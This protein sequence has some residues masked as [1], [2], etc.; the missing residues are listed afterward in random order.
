MQLGSHPGVAARKPAGGFCFITV[1]QL[2]MAWWAKA[3]GWIRFADLR[4]YLAAH[5]VLAKRCGLKAGVPPRFDLVELCRL[6]GLSLDRVRA[7]LKRLAAAGL[8][9]WS[10]SALSF[11]ESPD[12]L[13]ADLSGFLEF[14]DRIPNHNRRVPVP[15]RILR[16]MAGARPAMIATILGHLFRCLYYRDGRCH[17]YGRCKASWIADTFGVALR[18]VKEARADLIEQGWLLPIESDQW[19]LNRWGAAFTINLAWDRTDSVTAPAVSGP[20]PEPVA[21]PVPTP[22]LAPPPAGFSPELA[23]PREQETLLPVEEE[24]RNQEPASGGPAGFSKSQSGPEEHPESAP[25]PP[26]LQN[27]VPADLKDTGRLFELHEQAQ[28]AGLIGSSESDRL[29]FVAAAEHARAVGSVNP[30]GLFVRI[31]RSKLYPFITQDDEDAANA[32]IKRHLYGKPPSER[33]EGGPSRPME[34]S[35]PRLSED[36]L[37]VQAVKA[38]LARAGY[39]GDPFYALK[40]QRP[41]WTRDRWDRALAEL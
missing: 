31:I 33:V 40:G 21:A 41:E 24:L 22:E 3:Q 2:A 18:R 35:R 34:V 6:T 15:R 39:R 13:N 12:A 4:V 8:M 27:V 20:P 5:E 29:K 26:T 14:L 37:L 23:P 7:S 25:A 28:A 10:Q 11:A 1:A 16:L 36:A 9:S 19:Q 32:R 17:S 38:A 30:P